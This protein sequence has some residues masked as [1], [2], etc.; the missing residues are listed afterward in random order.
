[1][2]LTNLLLRE[3]ARRDAYKGLAECFHLPGSNLEAILKNLEYQL[4]ILSSEALYHVILMR[5]EF[6]GLGDPDTFTIDFARLFV[7]PYRLEA[8]PY[9]SVYLEEERKAMGSSTMDVKELYR[10]SGLQIAPDF[11]DAPDHIAAELEFMYVLIYREIEAIRKDQP[12]IA[13][14]QMHQQKSFLQYHIGAWAGLFADLVEEYAQTGFYRSL[15]KA[16]KI[17]VDED[18]VGI[19]EVTAPFESAGTA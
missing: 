8:P 5:S 12:K 10:E 4:T 1:M 6:Q 17:Y 3:E 14:E 16:T 7:G 15:A 9:G 11:R 18:V 13:F 19:S 2:K